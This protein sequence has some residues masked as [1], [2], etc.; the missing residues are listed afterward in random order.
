MLFCRS[1]WLHIDHAHI[2]FTLP[3]I[4]NTCQSVKN[5]T[6]ATAHSIYSLQATH[7][8]FQHIRSFCAYSLTHLLTHLLRA[9]ILF[10]QTLSLYKSLTYLLTYLLI[11]CTQCSNYMEARVC[12]VPSLISLPH[13]AHAVVEN[14]G[15]EGP[16]TRVIT[17]VVTRQF[18]YCLYNVCNCNSPRSVSA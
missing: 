1:D 5:Q 9:L 17:R 7:I 10:I 16:H 14:L 4:I 12:Q 18:D 6:S 8:M 2:N 3:Y 13:R 15:T 11:A